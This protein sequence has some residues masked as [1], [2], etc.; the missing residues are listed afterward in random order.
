MDTCSYQNSSVVVC[1]G[2]LAL[3]TGCGAVPATAELPHYRCEHGIA[4]TVRFDGE[5]AVVDSNRGF[6]VLHRVPGA[7]PH[8]WSSP[9]LTAQFG[10][11]EA[12]REATLRYPL[13]PLAARC[14]LD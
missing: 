14:A 5:T 11:G 10:Q 12:G 1:V 8:T 9:R 4:F 6:E 7:P 2:W 3:L 13:L